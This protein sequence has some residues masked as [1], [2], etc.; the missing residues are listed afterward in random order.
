[1]QKHEGTVELLNEYLNSE[2]EETFSQINNLHGED[3]DVTIIPTEKN[4]SIFISEITIGL[5]QEELI[6]KIATNSFKIHQ[7]EVEKFAN[8]NQMFKNQL[9]D[10]I[11]EACDEFLDGEALIEEEDDNYIMEES[12]YKVITK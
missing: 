1:M 7:D 6:K 11:N 4:N 2:K 5:V 8:E 10:S 9:I 3:I 12:Y